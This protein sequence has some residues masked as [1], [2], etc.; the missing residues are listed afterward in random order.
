MHFK[1][2]N[3]IFG[4]N[5]PLSL[6]HDNQKCLQKSGMGGEHKIAHSWEPLVK[7]DQIFNL[8]LWWTNCNEEESLFFKK[9]PPWNTKGTRV[10]QTK[11]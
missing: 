2:F 8:R 5:N 4:I 7:N 3:S 1:M 6:S 9:M 11:T 10:K